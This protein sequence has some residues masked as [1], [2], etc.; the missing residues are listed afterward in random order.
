MLTTRMT[1]WLGKL[2]ERLGRRR[3]LLVLVVL[4]VAVLVIENTADFPLSVPYLRR[5]TGH[6]YLDMCA[7]CSD[8]SVY[9]VLDGFGQHG[10]TLQGL[11]MVTVDI[12]IPGL[13][14]LFGTALIGALL[15]GR[16]QTDRR[17][18]LLL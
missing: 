4:E 18:M 15:Q 2:A 14:F 1:A 12:L 17:R 11:L 9:A 10:R 5:T 16:A 6:E 8:A 3:T 7:F 13:S